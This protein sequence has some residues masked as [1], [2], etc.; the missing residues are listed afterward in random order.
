MVPP[1]RP[2]MFCITVMFQAKR[3]ILISIMFFSSAP[4]FGSV[5]HAEHEAKTRGAPTGYVGGKG[6]TTTSTFIWPLLPRIFKQRFVGLQPISLD[7][8]ARESAT[9]GWSD[10]G[11]IQNQLSWTPRSNKVTFWLHHQTYELQGR[12]G[13]PLLTDTK[14]QESIKNTCWLTK[15]STAVVSNL[16][17]WATCDSLVSQQLHFDQK[18]K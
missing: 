5:H 6:Y 8:D 4:G 2:I 13:A 1:F 18:Y 7:V 11:A 9:P 15:R 10:S 17:L 3:L 14:Q 12:R 16:W